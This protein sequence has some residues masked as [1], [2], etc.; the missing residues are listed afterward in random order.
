MVNSLEIE[1]HI[2][3]KVLEKYHLCIDAI[4][5]MNNDIDE[6]IKQTLSFVNT[7]DD[8]KI[9]YL[10]KLINDM[11]EKQNGEYHPSVFEITPD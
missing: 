8:M 1:V 7:K 11:T 5:D 6:L 3:K 10:R 2:N 4:R 9:G